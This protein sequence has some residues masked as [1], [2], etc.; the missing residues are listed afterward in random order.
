MQSPYFGLDE[1]ERRHL[2][3]MLIEKHP[4]KEI[5]VSVVLK[6]WDDIFNSQIGS[7]SIGKEIFPSPQ[8]ISF[9]VHELIAQYLSLKYPD[10]YKVGELKNE[11]DVHDML[12]PKMGIEIKG[13]SNPT[14]IFAN[15]SY[16]Q[17]SSDSEEKDKN[18]YYLTFNFEKISK[19]NPRPKILRISFGY[20]EHSDWVA[21]ASATGQQARLRTEAYRDKLVILY[22]H[23]YDSRP[24]NNL[25]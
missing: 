21:Q 11:K 17:P 18:G 1:S 7:F 12:D 13:S 15:R 8:I 25:F 14:Q 3:Q 6:S 4:L 5:L 19:T 2:T 16:A 20:L 23:R 22:D 9:F 10:R 24:Q